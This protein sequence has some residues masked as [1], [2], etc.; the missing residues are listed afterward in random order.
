MAS[1]GFIREVDEELQRDR[2]AQLWK[3]FGPIVVGVALVVILATTGKIGWDAWQARQSERQGAA[4]AAAQAALDRD[5]PTAAAELFAGIAS[6]HRGDVA[7]VARLREAEARLAGGD[8]AAALTL[9][10]ALAE[11]SGIDP[12]L[13]EFAAVAAAQRRLGNADPAGLL[14]ALE[15]HMA[16][17]APFRHSAREAAALAAIEAGDEGAAVEILRQ[18]Q[19]DA[20]TPDAMRQR[21]E[22]LLATLGA[23]GESVTA[24]EDA[25]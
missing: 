21:A 11:T 22:E 2:M 20:S 24:S 9:L 5:D 3:R 16:A 19:A 14:A 7:A 13:R 23:A 25:Q 12:I 17:D 4:F 10:D 6:D 18:L 15:P 1:D 8:E